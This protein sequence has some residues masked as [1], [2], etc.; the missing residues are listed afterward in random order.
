MSWFTPR[1]SEPRRTEPVLERPAERRS[2]VNV[3][4]GYAGLATL[5]GMGTGTGAEGLAVVQACVGAIAGG[6]ASLPARAYRTTGSGRVELTTGPLARL[7][8]APNER[9]TWP[10]LLEWLLASALLRGNA[11]AAITRDATGQ[12]VALTPIPWGSVS[13]SVLPSG[14][15]AYDVVS[16][17]GPPRRYLAGEVFHLRDR[18]DDS[19]ILGRSRIS[20]APAALSNATSLQDY[21]EAVWANAATPS[22][23]VTAPPN[24]SKDGMA[25]LREMT[26]QRHGGARN[27]KRLFI[28]EA[29]QGFVP[30][31]VSPEDAEVLASR[32]FSVIE[33]CRLFNVPPPIVQDYSNST[34]TNASQAST[35]FGTNTLAPWARKLEAEFSRSVL[36]DPAN[37]IEIDLSGLLR[38]DFTA[39]WT[40]WKIAVD[41]NI[42]DANEVREAEGYSPRAT[43]PA[44]PAAA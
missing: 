23:M 27:A 14:R 26:E 29:G 35:W 32:K 6:L 18:L 12:A 33:L 40:A 9:L 30:F 1:R 38:G 17:R 2:V 37:H 3:E 11:L 19:G 8:Q 15:L 34:F 13:V 39:R 5:A 25:R 41:S 43:P 4:P 16:G 20:R 24:I 22:G 21:S 44:P 7:L 42:L 36:V 28:G 10:D 31:S